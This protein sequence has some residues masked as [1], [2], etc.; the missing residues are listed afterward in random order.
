MY[1]FICPSIHSFI[2]LHMYELIYLFIYSFN[3]FFFHLFIYLSIYSFIYL[4][5]NLF[6]TYL[7][8]LFTIWYLLI[9]Q[10][11]FFHFFL[12]LLDFILFYII[13]L[14]IILFFP[15]FFLI[16]GLAKNLVSKTDQDSHLKAQGL[17][18]IERTSEALLIPAIGKGSVKTTKVML[19]LDKVRWGTKKKK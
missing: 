11:L 17:K 8:I 4:Y 7:F 9:S 10:F 19:D 5:F 16:L 2:Y 1:S 6:F 14:L 15:L 3:C 18:F 13:L 12:F